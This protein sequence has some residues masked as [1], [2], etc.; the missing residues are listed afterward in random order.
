LPV[1]LTL[2]TRMSTLLLIH[3]YHSFSD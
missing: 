1:V 3:N 2:E